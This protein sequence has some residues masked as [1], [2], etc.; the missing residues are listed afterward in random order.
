MA[1]IPADILVRHYGNVQR[2]RKDFCQRPPCL[3]E[4]NNEWCWGP[5]ETGKSWYA[6]STSTKYYIKNVNKWWDG[7]DNQELVIIE[8]VEKEHGKFFGHF[9]KLFADIYPF[10]AEIKGSSFWIR[11]K[12][13]IVCTNYSIEDIFEHDTTLIKAIKRRFKVKHFKLKW[14]DPFN[15]NNSL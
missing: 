15:N 13:I 14:D 2:I 3:D 5:S 7:Y 6:R 8:E 9:L 11:P 12:R 4:L 1:A 10:I